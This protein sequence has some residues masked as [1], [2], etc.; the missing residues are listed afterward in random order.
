MDSQSDAKIGLAIELAGFA[1]IIGAGVASL[2]HVGIMTALGL[3]ALA[4][5]CGRKIRAGNVSI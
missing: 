2:H 3:G 1:A 4:I 5:V